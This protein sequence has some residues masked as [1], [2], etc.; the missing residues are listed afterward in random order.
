MPFSHSVAAQIA[1]L[2]NEQNQLTVRYTPEMIL[3]HEDRYLIRSGEKSQVMGVVEAKRVQWYQLEIDHLSVDPVFTRRGVG[4]ELVEDAEDRARQLGAR[5]A[6]CT[7][8]AGNAASEALFKKRGY[9]PTVTFWNEGT[10]NKVTV[11]QKVLNAKTDHSAAPLGIECRTKIIGDYAKWTVLSALRSGAPIKSRKVVYT[12]LGTIDFGVLLQ[13]NAPPIQIDEFD[14]WHKAA[15]VSLCE[16]R[17]DLCAGWAAKM[18]NIYLKTAVY[19]GGLGRSGLTAALHP[20]IDGGLWSGLSR[21]FKGDALLK[22]T[23]VVTKIKDI[24][25]YPTYE[26]VIAGCR[27]AA[28]KLNCR[29]IE[30]D[31]LWEGSD[32]E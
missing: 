10:E 7:I 32:P 13:R 12:L 11:Y 19:A 26:T 29:L 2:L 23:H 25:D 20:P 6:Q 30:V 4:S 18:I 1:D 8:R 9:W 5:I 28:E 16:Q 31:Q 27:L 3:E 17:P 21:R 22:K 24:R 15:T 14:G